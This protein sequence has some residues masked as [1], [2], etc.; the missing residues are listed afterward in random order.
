MKLEYLKEIRE[1]LSK[2]RTYLG[3][4]DFSIVNKFDPKCIYGIYRGSMMITDVNSV[5]LINHAKKIDEIIV[6]LGSPVNKLIN[7]EEFMDDLFD[8]CYSLS[9]V[10]L[11]NDEDILARE[12]RLYYEQFLGDNCNS[13]YDD[14]KNIL[15]GVSNQ[16]MGCVYVPTKSTKCR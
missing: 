13:F 15:I 8:Y 7:I 9:H 2:T 10:S 3:V 1:Y 4:A 16:A 11:I 5:Y 6:S 14:S 12:Q